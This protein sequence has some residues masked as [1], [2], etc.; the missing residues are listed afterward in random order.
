M[1]QWQSRNSIIGDEY[2]WPKTIPY[3]MEDDLGKT[4][5]NIV[6]CITYFI[7]T[8][9]IYFQYL[10]QYTVFNKSIQYLILSQ[11]FNHITSMKYYLKI[12]LY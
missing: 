5:L 4:A 3:Y 1:L 10:I 2:R 9:I 11:V 6:L 7:L 8:H 12:G